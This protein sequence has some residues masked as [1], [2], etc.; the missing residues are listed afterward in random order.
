[1]EESNKIGNIE[2]V[3]INGSPTLKSENTP[4]MEPFYFNKFYDERS[5]KK[6]IKNIER[7]IRSSREYKIYVELLRTNLT[8]LNLDN[9]LSNITINDADLE[10]HHYPFTLYDIVDVIVMEKFMK[11]EKFTSFGISKEVMDLHYQNIIGLVPL[12]KTNHELAHNGDIFI[13]TKQIFG[14]YKDFIKKY[15]EAVTQELIE[16]VKDIETKSLNN[17]P[18]DFKGLL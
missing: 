17:H 15:N 8:A 9:I 1:M 10:F 5:Y 6:F 13:S 16:K 3:V 7:T 4:F 11:K 14:N 18:S 12:T 2:S